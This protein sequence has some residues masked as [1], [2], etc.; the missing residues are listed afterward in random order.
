MRVARR[1]KMKKIIKYLLLGIG[2]FLIS[3]KLVHA[4]NTFL[5]EKDPNGL[6]YKIIKGNRVFRLYFNLVKDRESGEL[7]YCLEPGVALSEEWYQEWNEWD[8]A[9]LNLSEKQKKFITKVAYFGYNYQNHENLSYYY[10][11]QLLIWESI[12][13]E[14]WEIYYTEKL[15]GLKVNWFQKEREEILSLI[16]KDNKLPTFAY[17]EFTINQKESLNLEDKNQVL[18][19][20]NLKENLNIESIKKGNKLYIKAKNHKENKLEFIK[21]YSGNSIKFYS[22]EDGQNVMRRGKLEDQTFFVTLKTYQPQIIIHKTDEIGNP[23]SEVEFQLYA[24]E[25][26]QDKEGNKIF[27][28]DE[29][30]TKKKTD[31]KGILI[32]ENLYDGNYCI[33]ET[34]TKEGYIL[35]KKPICI[36]I[37]QENSKKNI[38][39]TNEKRNKTLSSKKKMLKQTKF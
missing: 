39:W 34:K 31:G 12:I 35:S 1:R 4:S 19:Q 24:G 14:D 32:F 5:L 11:A 29:R 15:G 37:S 33:L 22:R 30:I 17:Q 38:K 10:A 23:L 26:I 28:K 20:Y 8:Y 13:P 36:E 2:L 7:V 3:D 16:E 18:E 27:D 6:T 21:E 9:K 25:V